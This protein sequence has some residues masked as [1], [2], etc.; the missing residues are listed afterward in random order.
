MKRAHLNY[1][2]KKYKLA[3]CSEHRGVHLKY[4]QFIKAITPLV[5]LC[6]PRYV[7]NRLQLQTHLKLDLKIFFRLALF[8][9]LKRALLQVQQK[10]NGTPVVNTHK[11]CLTPGNP[12]LI[13]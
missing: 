8:T 5:F 10:C 2:Y 12:L 6:N 9:F 4:M 1:R 3:A 13:F 11:V 7:F